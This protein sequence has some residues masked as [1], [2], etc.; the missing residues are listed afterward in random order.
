MKTLQKYT[1]HPLL[2]LMQ[3]LESIETAAEFKDRQVEILE[4]IH[5]ATPILRDRAPECC[6]LAK[7]PFLRRQGSPCTP[8]LM[9]RF[10]ESRVKETLAL[11]SPPEK[12]T[13]RSNPSRRE[14][15]LSTGF[16]SQ[17]AA[18]ILTLTYRQLRD[19]LPAVHTIPTLGGRND[20]KFHNPSFG[21]LMAI[22]SKGKCYPVTASDWNNACVIRSRNPHNPWASRHYTGI[23]SFYSYGLILAAAL[24]RHVEEEGLAEAGENGSA[25]MAEFI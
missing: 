15:S 14:A 8:Y 16:I 25:I 18:P 6:R 2:P 9:A 11:T 10:I 7:G 5:L 23:S 19:S 3:L 4:A 17:H 12:S 1:N 20:I 24:L 22:N 21:D 13:P